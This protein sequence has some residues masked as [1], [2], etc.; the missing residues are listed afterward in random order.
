[1]ITGPAAVIV[2]VNCWLTLAKLWSN[3]WT[4]NVKVPADDG[5]PL[6]IPLLES[7]SIPGGVIPELIHQR[8]GGKPPV[9]TI[10][11]E[12]GE[13]TTPLGN[14]EA[15]LIV[16]GGLMVKLNVLVA[17]TLSLSVTVTPKLNVPAVEVLPLSRP[18]ELSEKF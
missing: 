16:S 3:T 4:V 12:Y 15:V 18:E 2:S 6:S 10:G 13:F 9:A 17:V 7:M 1:M 8:Y 5:V 14:G 11:C